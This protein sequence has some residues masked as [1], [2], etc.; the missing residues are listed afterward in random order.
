MQRLLQEQIHIFSPEA[1]ACSF[2][3]FHSIYCRAVPGRGQEVQGGGVSDIFRYK[4]Q[5]AHLSLLLA[6]VGMQRNQA[7]LSQ[8]PANNLESSGP[9]SPLGTSCKRTAMNS[10]SKH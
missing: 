9:S 6:G 7:E 1:S 2:L 8:Q 3:E 4:E 5:Q 10:E